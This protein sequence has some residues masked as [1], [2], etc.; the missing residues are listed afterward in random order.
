M[1]VERKEDRDDAGEGCQSSMD[2]TGEAVLGPPQTL[3]GGV[4]NSRPFL[5]CAAQDADYESA[6]PFSTFRLLSFA[7]TCAGVRFPG[8]IHASGARSFLFLVSDWEICRKTVGS[9]QLSDFETSR[10]HIS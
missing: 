4:K 1:I 5:F 7:R 10:L 6:Q 8:Q 2:V 3:K 9:S